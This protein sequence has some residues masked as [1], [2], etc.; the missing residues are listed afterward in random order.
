MGHTFLLEEGEEGDAG[1]DLPHDG[2]D[3]HLDLLLRLLHHPVC[4]GQTLT[5]ADVGLSWLKSA[6]I[7]CAGPPHKNEPKK[8]SVNV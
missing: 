2:L 6:S 4:G 1:G 3:L 8:S 7:V 5:V